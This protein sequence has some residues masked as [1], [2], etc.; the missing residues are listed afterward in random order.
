MI[1]KQQL[2]ELERGAPRRASD[3]VSTSEQQPHRIVVVGGGAGGLELVTRLGDRLGRKG[4]AHVTLIDASRTHVWK[5][6]LHEFAAGTLGID[7][8]ALDYIAQARWHHF[9]F[10]LGAMEGLDREHR[11]VIIAPS[12]SEEGEEVTPRRRIGYDT[13]VIAV[14]S[15]N[16]D[17]GTPGVREHAIQLE[18]KEDAGRFHRRLID[19]CLRANTQPEPERISV[20][21]VGGGATGVELCA[22]LH[23]A[24]RV[25]AS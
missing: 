6:L 18:T 3:V 21:V 14:G 5:P 13:L 24:M 4:R 15:M 17:F 20:A 8:H 22:E 12:Y 9:S 25:L 23:N 10:R 1:L 11:E 7:G 19:A 16:N 2:V